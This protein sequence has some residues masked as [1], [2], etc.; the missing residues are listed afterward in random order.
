MSVF[1]MVLGLPY[2]KV[3]IHRLRTSALVRGESGVQSGFQDSMGY[4]MTLYLKIITIIFKLHI[5]QTILTDS[6][7]SQILR[8]WKVDYEEIRE[9]ISIFLGRNLLILCC[10]TQS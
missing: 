6:E 7:T 3:S 8:G 2:E 10:L 4:R 9:L 5:H 1:S